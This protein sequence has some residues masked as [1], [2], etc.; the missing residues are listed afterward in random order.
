MGVQQQQVMPLAEV[1]RTLAHE[2]VP[3]DLRRASTA[4]AAA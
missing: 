1:I 4:A 2:A 3:P